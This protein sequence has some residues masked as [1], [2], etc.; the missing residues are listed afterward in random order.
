MSVTCPN[1]LRFRL[2]TLD[3]TVVLRSLNQKMIVAAAFVL[4][5]VLMFTTL[6][7]SALLTLRSK[8][9]HLVTIGRQA[10]LSGDLDTNI[11]RAAGEL[12]TLI[13]TGR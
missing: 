2:I 12:A 3:K 5:V 7:A 8:A 10:E 4:V 11:V 1:C 6:A 9:N 13:A